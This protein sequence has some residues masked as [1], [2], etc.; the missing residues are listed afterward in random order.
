MLDLVT[1]IASDLTRPFDTAR[2]AAGVVATFLGLALVVGASFVRTMVPLR[3][4][5][6][7][8]NVL[9]LTAAVLNPNPASILIYLVL[10]PLN[11][12][13][14]MEI[15]RLTRRVIEASEQ[16]E[17]SGVWLK[18]YMKSRRLPAGTM[19]FSK[20]DPADS[21]YLLVE[22]ELEWV[23]IG[24]RQAPGE[25]FGEISFFAPDHARTLSARC[26]T[27]CVVLGIVESTFK[28]LY[29]QNPTFAFHV[30]GLITQRL[31]ADIE[32]L[33]KRVGELEA[34]ASERASAPAISA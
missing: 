20:G 23:E 18:P 6:V 13:R 24:K 26:V 14:L 32:R 28:Q 22:G 17:L 19:L 10:I 16:R 7:L 3:T 8:S 27:E 1:G 25:L 4:L 21:L 31:G 11:S 30:S 33:R 15:V 29:F 34:Q 2:G 12:Y 5:T 9:L